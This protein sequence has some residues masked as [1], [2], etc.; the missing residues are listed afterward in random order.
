MLLN[1]GILPCHGF[2]KVQCFVQFS[3][4]CA[5]RYEYIMHLIGRRH[6][7]GACF[8]IQ[9]ERLGNISLLLAGN[10]EATI[11]HI[12]Q[13]HMSRIHF[14]RQTECKHERF[15]VPM[16]DSG[17][18]ETRVQDGIWSNVGVCQTVKNLL[19]CICITH[20]GKC[21]KKGAKSPL[22]CLNIVR[23]HLPVQVKSCIHIFGAS[24]DVEH[25]VVRHNIWE[26]TIRLHRLEYQRC[27]IQLLVFA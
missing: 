17:M 13:W 24:R 21:V 27:N 1:V 9:C 19:C 15:L 23:R 2:H 4:P 3:T 22:C 10:Q 8:L 6:S 11:C 18:Y 12:C 20:G 14:I 5:Y 7:L 16:L 26:R 25:C